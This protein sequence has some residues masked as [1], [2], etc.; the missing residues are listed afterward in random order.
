MC[1][2]S[3]TRPDNLVVFEA[4]FEDSFNI[5]DRDQRRASARPARSRGR[6]PVV[7]AD[8]RMPGMTGAELFEIMRRSRLHTRRVML[9]GYADSQAMIDAINQGHV[10]Y[11]LKKPWERHEVQ[12]VLV[13]AIE[14]YELEL[15]NLTLTD[16]LVSRR[17]LRGAGPLGGSD[18]SRD[19]QP[20][21]HVAATG[22]DRGSIRRPR[23]PG[24]DGGL[25]PANV[26]AA[27]PT[28]Q[29]GQGVRPLRATTA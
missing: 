12:S 8:Q 3:T 22:T 2:M 10:Y 25:C 21:V 18:R 6:F 15:S 28:D 11:F 4:T 7:V 26:R 20:A 1:S 14:A 9:T 13:R 23:R 24:P 19:G 5:C 17:P 16:R 27:R 29:R